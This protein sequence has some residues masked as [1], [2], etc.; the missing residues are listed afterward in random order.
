MPRVAD[1]EKLEPSL[2]LWLGR[3][4][5]EF[6][7]SCKFMAKAAGDLIGH[8]SH[9]AD[10]VLPEFTANLLFGD[11]STDHAMNDLPSSFGKAISGLFLGRNRDDV[12]MVAEDPL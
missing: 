7:R 9:M 3:V 11:I 12:A 4:V 8:E 5:D 10:S 6:E 2:R 1:G